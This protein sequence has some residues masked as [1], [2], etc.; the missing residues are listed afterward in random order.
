MFNEFYQLYVFSM[1]W[2]A[3]GLD[4]GDGAPVRQRVKGEPRVEPVLVTILP[5]KMGVQNVTPMDL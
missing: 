4:G 1:Q 3:S 2:T 5:Q